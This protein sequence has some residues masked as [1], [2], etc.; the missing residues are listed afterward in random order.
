MRRAIALACF[1]AS[2]WACRPAPPSAPDVASSGDSA[3]ADVQAMDVAAM[4]ASACIAAATAAL[5]SVELELRLWD[6]EPA[7]RVEF[8]WPVAPEC[9]A[10]VS[11]A[12]WLE[13]T[14]TNATRTA[15]VDTSALRTGIHR[16]AIELR[17]SDGSVL[18]S[19]SATLRLFRPPA[20]RDDR[21]VMVIGYDGARPDAVE[22]AR[23][24]VLDFLRRR[25][26]QSF[27]ARTQLAAQ[28][29]SAPGWM[30]TF[31]GVDPSRHRV[32]SNGEY[33][34]RDSA[35]RTFVARAVDAGHRAV[36]STAWEEVTTQI[37]ETSLG[38]TSVERNFGFDSFAARWLAQRARTGVERL[39]VQ[40]LN[41][42]DAAGH[43]TGFSLDNPR[44]IEAIESCDQNLGVLID[45]VLARAT[46]AREDWLFVLTTDHGGRGTTHGPLDDDNRRIWF[47]ASGPS[48]TPATIAAGASHMDTAPTVLDWLGVAID[49]SWGLQGVSRAR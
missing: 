37:V 5:S 24:P 9:G 8:A 23:T 21:R 7:P 1:S 20:T 45:G 22:A 29:V 14:G 32:V 35:H 27:D 42:P 25:A 31:T 28:T 15:Q 10:L 26:V 44:Y 41:A 4:D 13:V 34:M 11:S 12:P 2:M 38:A 30:S 18:A 33:A 16:A 40:H 49:S 17:A 19:K 39:Y 47:V 46:V 36:V 48:I 3:A 43:S 6:G